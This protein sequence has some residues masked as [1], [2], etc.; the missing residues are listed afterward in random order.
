MWSYMQQY[1][2]CLFFISFSFFQNIMQDSM[3]GVISNY[4]N[5]IEIYHF[6]IFDHKCIV[7]LS[8]S[9]GPPCTYQTAV[10]VLI[11]GFDNFFI[12]SL[13]SRTLN[14]CQNTNSHP[15]NDTSISI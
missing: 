14:V 12:K 5:L 13:L 3:P 8:N 10:L 9:L 2:T 1:E 4:Q 15:K 7:E 11:L 6:V